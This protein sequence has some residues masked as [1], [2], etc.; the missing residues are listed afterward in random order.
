[1]ICPF[2]SPSCTPSATNILSILLFQ[3]FPAS[4]YVSESSTG[5]TPLSA[6]QSGWAGKPKR[7][8]ANTLVEV[9]SYYNGKTCLH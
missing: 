9:S 1:M 7:Q 2:F 5:Q 8:E 4:S 3:V 6:G